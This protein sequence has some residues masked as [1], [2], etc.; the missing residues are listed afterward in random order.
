MHYILLSFN[1]YILF[2]AE[3]YKLYNSVVN[4]QHV[5]KLTVVLNAFPK[6]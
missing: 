2:I 4:I 5:K 3:K 1:L 6:C